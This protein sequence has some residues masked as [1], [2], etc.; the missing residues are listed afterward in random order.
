MIRNVNKGSGGER[1]RGGRDPLG[2]LSLRVLIEPP[3]AEGNPQ[4]EQ[5]KHEGRRCIEPLV[6]PPAGIQKDKRDDANHETPG[7]EQKNVAMSQCTAGLRSF[8]EV[9]HGSAG[10][11]GLKIIFR[12]LTRCFRIDAE[13]R[14]YD[15]GLEAFETFGFD[16]IH[17]DA[18]STWKYLKAA[19]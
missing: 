2:S 18:P 10:L 8:H 15:P 3:H 17:W 11:F 13:L 14:F 12:N 7:A 16:W 5:T 6:E 1:Q 9:H 19:E 4:E